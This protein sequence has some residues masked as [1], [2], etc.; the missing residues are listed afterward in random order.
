MQVKP[1]TRSGALLVFAMA[2]FTV[3]SLISVTILQWT[4]Q[5]AGNAAG[6]L[7]E[8]QA[9]LSLRSAAALFSASVST[10]QPYTPPDTAIALPSARV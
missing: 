8:E 9:R 2:I 7:A 4:A 1:Q 5:S 6:S 10:S 3:F